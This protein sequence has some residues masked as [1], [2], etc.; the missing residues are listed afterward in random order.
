M[1]IMGLL[2]HVPASPEGAYVSSRGLL[3]A[4]CYWNDYNLIR[5]ENTEL[6]I[7]D[8]KEKDSLR[9]HLKHIHVSTLP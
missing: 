2:P 7:L 3:I 6:G 1:L 5:A 9:D 4:I 8:E